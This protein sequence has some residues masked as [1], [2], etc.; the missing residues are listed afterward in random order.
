VDGQV[1]VR[2]VWVDLDH[3]QWAISEVTES[4][5]AVVCC[6]NATLLAVLESAAPPVP[7][8]EL[9][10]K[11]AKYFPT[12]A[13]LTAAACV[14][15]LPRLFNGKVDYQSLPALFSTSSQAELDDAES[16]LVRCMQ[17]VD[18]FAGTIFASSFHDQ[19][20]T[21]ELIGFDSLKRAELLVEL[22]R[23]AGIE[24][25]MTDLEAPISKL[26]AQIR[27]LLA[28]AP[29]SSSSSSPMAAKRAQPQTGI[30]LHW[31]QPDAFAP[32]VA[33]RRAESPDIMV[34][35][36][37]N[38]VQASSHEPEAN[39]AHDNDDHKQY[40]VTIEP[41]WHQSME[42]CID[43]SACVLVNRATRTAIAVVGSHAH[44]VAAFDVRSG[45]QLWRTELC[46]WFPRR[47]ACESSD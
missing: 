31:Q 1:K 24:L 4:Q 34:I 16:L 10:A 28:T 7:L 35:E 12:E 36:R 26:I 32:Q 29:S 47:S 14:A 19:D 20:T 43:G 21:L 39:A 2:G 22:Q 40:A 23:A 15:V 11:L 5:A 25:Q 27:Q 44:I 6:D 17:A 13:R 33:V 41:V 9:N 18:E 3:L 42:K 8:H 38:R 30:S 37:C 46:K 45:A